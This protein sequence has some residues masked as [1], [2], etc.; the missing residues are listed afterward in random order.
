MTSYTLPLLGLLILAPLPAGAAPDQGAPDA[1]GTAAERAAAA[2]QRGTPTA[3]SQAKPKEEAPA[4]T[5]GKPESKED[6]PAATK[7]KSESKEAAPAATKGKPE[8]KE[9]AP[10][11]TKGK[12]KEGAAAQPAATKEE[13]PAPPPPQA[14]VDPAAAAAATTAATGY[15]TALKEKG[16]AAAPA[17]LHPAAL[18]RFK[19]LVMPRLKDEQARGTRTL[20]NATFG[21]DAGYP[22]A[23]AADPADFLTRFARLISAREPDAAPRFSGLTPLGVL[24]EGEQLHVLIRLTLGGGPEAV[25]RIEVVSLLPQDKDW[26]VLL[27]GRLQSLA[28]T[29]GSQPRADGPRSPQ[30]RLEPLPEGLPPA[31]VAPAGPA[32]P[33]PTPPTLPAPR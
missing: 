29:L 25:E 12:P 3:K 7:G 32:G 21:R 1:P 16:F 28:S 23:A 6:A 8:S 4:A 20:L 22:A 30:L 5:K 13:P 31:P 27:D 17:W 9:E 2:Q 15:L 24:R 19:D 33:Q 11:A 10:A 14:V 18:A 26:K